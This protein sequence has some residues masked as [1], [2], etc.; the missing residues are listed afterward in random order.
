MNTCTSYVVVA[1]MRLKATFSINT[2][3]V[4]FLAS[5]SNNPFPFLDAFYYTP[6]KVGA[7][8]IFFVPVLVQINQIGSYKLNMYKH[9]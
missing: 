6:G 9:N 2:I 3:S 8:L 5:A 4:Q 7:A 1:V